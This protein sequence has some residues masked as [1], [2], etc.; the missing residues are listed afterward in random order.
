MS[1]NSS[2]SISSWPLVFRCFLYFRRRSWKLLYPLKN[3][4]SLTLFCSRL[5]SLIWPIENLLPFRFCIQRG[6]SEPGQVGLSRIFL[7]SIVLPNLI[8]PK[9]IKLRSVPIFFLKFL[10]IDFAEN[11]RGAIVANHCTAAGRENLPPRNLVHRRAHVVDP[12]SV[13]IVLRVVIRVDVHYKYF[14]F[15]GKKITFGLHVE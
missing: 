14:V 8:F 10:T 7:N 3:F 13:E 11:A 4:E 9:K 5:F 12:R 6:N 2:S 1:L 15:Y